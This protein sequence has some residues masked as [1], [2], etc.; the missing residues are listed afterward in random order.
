MSN[1]ITNFFYLHYL[2]YFSWI[3]SWWV[4]F[5]L[6]MRKLI[7]WE[8]WHYALVSFCLNKCQGEKQKNHLKIA[9]RNSIHHYLTNI[10]FHWLLWYEPIQN[11]R[12]CCCSHISKRPRKRYVSRTF[13]TSLCRVWSAAILFYRLLMPCDLCHMLSWWQFLLFPLSH[14][15]STWFDVVS[16]MCLSTFH[17]PAKFGFAPLNAAPA[18]VSCY[19]LSSTNISSCR[20]ELEGAWLQCCWAGWSP[21][22][23]CQWSAIPFHNK[24]GW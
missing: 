16:G 7:K 1:T 13:H 18:L 11:C 21:G 17:L 22:S 24:K 12:H 9:N 23:C 10:I 8:K 2:I 5:I 19:H 4:P 3:S 14:S 20:E 15:F 6:N